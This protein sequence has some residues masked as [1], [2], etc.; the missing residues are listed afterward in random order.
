MQDTFPKYPNRLRQAIK[1]CGLTIQAVAEETNIPLRTLFD[2]CAGRVPIPKK[3]LEAIAN[4]T[5]YPPEYLIPAF[6]DA[7]GT[8]L[9]Q[10]EQADVW[11]SSGAVNKVDKLRRKLLQ[12]LLV[13][14]GTMLI[15]PREGLIG[16]DAWERL[17]L[18]LNNSYCVDAATLRHLEAL[19]DTYWELYRS[20]IA[21]I[22]M[23]SSV[24]GHLFAVTR[25]LQSSQPVAAQSRLC[26]IA[27][28]TAQIIGEIYFDMNDPK[29]ADAYYTLAI[30]AAQEVDDR[31]LWA[32]ALGRKGFLSIYNGEFQKA[33]PFFQEAY[34]L[35]EQTTTGKSKSWLTMMESEALSHLK[36]KDDCFATLE[37]TER[38]F[39]QDRSPTGVDKHWTGFSRSTLTGYKGV[40]YMR[41]QLP[42]EAQSLLRASLDELSPGPTRRRSI[43]LTDLALTYL[44]QK[45]VEEACEVASQ[46]LL[47]AVHTKSTRALQR[48][49]NF[50]NELRTWKTLPCVK[51]FNE[52]L[53]IVQAM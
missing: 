8:Y 12:Q 41:L 2:Y 16:T 11:I 15:V 4:I 28:N 44:Q 5:G 40:C 22:D 49:R 47:C 23:L 52:Q 46:A 1:Q 32:I 35:A 51:R 31:A 29:T 53:R 18:A 26:S 19:T 3:R 14:A 6:A 48:L 25:L 7:G 39:D 20:A 24:S 37:K 10:S 27:S 42:G 33:L 45:K 34:G 50:Q 21:K 36:R 38:V 9:L 13:V 43:I 17:S 30:E